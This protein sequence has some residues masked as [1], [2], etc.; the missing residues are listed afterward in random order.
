MLDVHVIIAQDTPREWVSQCLD[1][2]HE[3]IDRA[4]FAIALHI[5]PFVAG[6]VGRARAAGYAMGSHPY[7]T[8]VDDDDY[9][10][11]HAFEQ[12]REPLLAGVAA[13]CTPEFTLQNGHQRPGASRHHLVA[14]R[15]GWII[16]HTQWKCCG[17]VAQLRAV[18]ADAVDLPSAAYVHRLYGTSKARVLRRAHHDE[19]ELARAQPSSH[20]IALEG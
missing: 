1:S 13:A 16:D 9:L 3:A 8:C 7:V 18:E 2:V 19:L 11:P 4:G 17:D 20:R 15:R 5:A 14:I 12:M 6:H 10:L